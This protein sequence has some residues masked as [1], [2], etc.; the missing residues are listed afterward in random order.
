MP[1]RLS[2]SPGSR[3]ARGGS[4]CARLLGVLNGDEVLAIVVVEA[5]RGIVALRG[6]PG[7]GDRPGMAQ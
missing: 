2:K 7:D 6:L 5:A 1:R 3:R 4:V